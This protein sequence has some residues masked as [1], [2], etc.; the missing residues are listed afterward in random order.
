MPR[1]VELAADKPFYDLGHIQ[2]EV[3]VGSDTVAFDKVPIVAPAPGLERGGEELVR[4]LTLRVKPGE[5]VLI[6]GPN[7]VA[8]RPSRVWTCIWRTC[9]RARAAGRRARSGRMCCRAAR[10]SEWGWRVLLYQPAALRHPGR[11]HECRVDGRRGADVCQG[12]GSGHHAHHDLASSVVVQV[13]RG[14]ARDSRARRAR[15][16]TDYIGAET[17]Q[18]EHGKRDRRPGA[19]DGRG[20]RGGR[21]ASARSKGALA[22]PELRRSRRNSKSRRGRR[23]S[24][25]LRVRLAS[26]LDLELDGCC[27]AIRLNVEGPLE[28]GCRPSAIVGAAAFAMGFAQRRDEWEEVDLDWQAWEAGPA[29]VVPGRVDVDGSQTQVVHVATWRQL[30]PLELDLTQPQGAIVVIDDIRVRFDFGR[31]ELRICQS[32]DGNLAWI[33]VEPVHQCDQTCHRGRWTIR[34]MTM[35]VSSRGKPDCDSAGFRPLFGPNPEAKLDIAHAPSHPTSSWQSYT[36]E[37]ASSRLDCADCIDMDAWSSPWNDD[38]GVAQPA[39]SS[40]VVNADNKA[41]PLALPPL[42][43]FDASDPWS[44]DVATPRPTEQSNSSSDQSPSLQPQ[45]HEA[46]EYTAPPSPL[47]TE[48]AWGDATFPTSTSPEVPASSFSNHTRATA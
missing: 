27:F 14:A 9:R 1:P 17:E 34:R 13:P 32:L 26:K 42:P 12:Q 3:V 22:Q 33:A 5:H 45:N 39:A 24:D 19:Q 30:F 10:S 4:D 48:S 35:V 2:G 31:G 40:S 6:T 28:P 18:A 16:E 29:L 25:P 21:A 37:E 15:G 11:V 47:Q 43:T 44:T 7:G 38:D 23:S 8:R 46:K 41:S 36:S 20:G